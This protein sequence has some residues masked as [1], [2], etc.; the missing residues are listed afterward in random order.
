MILRRLKFIFGNIFSYIF[1]SLNGLFLFFEIDGCNFDS[2]R[3]IEYFFLL[4][5]IGLNQ[6][7]KNYASVNVSACFFIRHI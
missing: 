5:F 4:N 7:N 6:I 1:H 3:L 2:I